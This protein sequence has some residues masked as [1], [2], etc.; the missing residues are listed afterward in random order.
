MA[1]GS[2]PWGGHSARPGRAGG[3]VHAEAPG[4]LWYYH[5]WLPCES[6]GRLIP[7]PQPPTFPGMQPQTPRASGIYATSSTEQALGRSR[8]EEGVDSPSLLRPLP[9]EGREAS[10]KGLGRQVETSALPTVGAPPRAA[11]SSRIQGQGP[12]QKGNSGHLFEKF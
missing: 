11:D 7:R 9:F 3:H 1:S 12:V 5:T 6:R 2:S 4:C 8:G 10:G